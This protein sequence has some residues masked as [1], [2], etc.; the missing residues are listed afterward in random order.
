MEKSYDWVQFDVPFIKS[1][2][3]ALE[4]SDEDVGRMFMD[5]LWYAWLDEYDREKFEP[6]IPPVLWEAVRLGITGSNF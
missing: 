3:R 1:L 5:C 6:T 4:L 2:I